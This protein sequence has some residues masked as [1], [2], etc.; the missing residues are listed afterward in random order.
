MRSL[1]WRAVW[2]CVLLCT[3]VQAET[4]LQ[5]TLASVNYPPLIDDRLR[6]GGVLTQIVDAVCK[7][8]GIDVRFETV[9]NNR[10]MSG[11][12][13]GWYSGSYGWSHSPERDAKLLF[14]TQPVYTF[15]MVFF[16]RKGE[17]F[18]WK[19]LADLA[20]YRIGMTAGNHYSD[21]FSRLITA[22]VLR[23]DE[24]TSELS[25]MRK[26]LAGR[27]DLFPMEETAGRFMVQT[28]FAPAEQ[29]KLEAQSKSMWD[30]PTYLVLRKDLA[31][32]TEL[33]SRFD[34]TFATMMKA[35]EIERIIDEAERDWMVRRR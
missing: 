10:A 21:E 29:L 12:M 28:E 1:Y 27:I 30:V 22:K 14:S 15:H 4:R 11:M 16:Q 34:R 33:M 23:V 18:P 5:L 3:C 24:A 6:G 19:A 32:A 17:V 13:K 26:L 20:P 25:N 9:P 2:V 35:R 31:N 8:A 7:R